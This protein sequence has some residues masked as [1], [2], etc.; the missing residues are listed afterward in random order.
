MPTNIQLKVTGFN[1][2]VTNH[3]DPYLSPSV[4]TLFRS[5]IASPVIRTDEAVLAIPVVRKSFNS[6]R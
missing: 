3:L 1:Q 5:D 6:V 4:S 2:L